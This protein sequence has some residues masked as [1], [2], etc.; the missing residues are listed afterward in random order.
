LSFK[1]KIKRQVRVLDVG[2]REW[3]DSLNEGGA[4]ASDGFFARVHY[5]GLK[6]LSM[7]ERLA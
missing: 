7:V 5:N 2:V 1:R 6:L 4:P 3:H